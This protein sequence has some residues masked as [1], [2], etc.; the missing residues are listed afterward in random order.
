MNLDELDKQM[1]GLV[2][3]EKHDDVQ[4]FTSSKDL[5]LMGFVKNKKYIS[6]LEEEN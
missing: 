1:D 3:K 4:S 5:K 6:S 2:I